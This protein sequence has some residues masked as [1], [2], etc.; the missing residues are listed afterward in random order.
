[1]PTKGWTGPSRSAIRKRRAAARRAD[2]A[3]SQ[4]DRVHGLPQPGRQLGAGLDRIADE[5]GPQLRR[6]APATSCGRW[7]TSG[8]FRINYLEHVGAIKGL[9]NRHVGFLEQ[10]LWT[11][12]SEATRLLPETP[13][14]VSAVIHHARQPIDAEIGGLKAE[15][16]QPLQALEKGLREQ[17]RNAPCCRAAGNLPGAGEPL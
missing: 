7:N 1:M 17:A 9:A 15:M 4:P 11:P 16:F 3:L 2:V 14:E 6:L 13:R 8:S 10:S 12:L 5:Q